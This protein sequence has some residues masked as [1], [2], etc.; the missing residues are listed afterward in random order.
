MKF[1]GTS[2]GDGPRIRNV[3]KLVKKYHDKG[4]EVVAVASAM[5]GVTDRLFEL[6][7]TAKDTSSVDIDRRRLRR[8]YKAA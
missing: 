4:N 5:T 8:A 3:A 1:G 2:V 6:A 7:Q